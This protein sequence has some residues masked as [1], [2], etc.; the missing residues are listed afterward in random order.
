M[1][2]TANHRREAILRILERSSKGLLM[3]EIAEQLQ[4]CGWVHGPVNKYS[5]VADFEAL[6][7][8]G[9]LRAPDERED[10]PTESMR[11]FRWELAANAEPGLRKGG[12]PALNE[13]FVPFRE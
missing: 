11:S 6:L 10:K 7:R 4:L 5:L 9:R 8:T 12:P 2:E 1:T 13:P 3:W